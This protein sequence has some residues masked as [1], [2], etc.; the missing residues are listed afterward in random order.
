MSL[1]PRVNDA[2]NMIQASDTA[3]IAERLQRK[4]LEA[5]SLQSVREQRARIFLSS[6][7][8]GL[9]IYIIS[10]VYR[11]RRKTDWLARR[12]DYE[13]LIKEIGVCFEG[14]GAT[15]SSAQA[16]LG[17]IQR[18]FT[19]DSCALALVDH[20]NRWAVESFAA[21]L[22]E[23][24][25]EG[26]GATRNGLFAK[27]DERASVFRIMSTRKVGCFSPEIPGLSILLAHKSTD[28][29]TAICSLSYQS[30]RLRPCPGEI[31]LLELATACL[32]HYI[33][34]RRKQSECD[35][36]ERRLE[37][38]ERLQAVGTLAGGIAH[39]F[40][41]ILGAILGYAEM[42]QTRCAGHRSPEDML[43]KLFRRVTE[44]GSL[45]I[46]S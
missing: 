26:R 41:N 46:R 11:L 36:L 23:P 25:W 37:H 3:E 7:S 31:Q 12:L 6:V 4:C 19:A 28:H 40:N 17:I 9:C 43:T 45:S 30:Y 35:I 42:A 33:D 27:A 20:G 10:L 5:Y 24:V 14:G 44:P 1:L 13:E 21:K 22:P 38:A 34:V 39:E 29:L 2:V 15:A 16:A 18:F 32:C 8:V